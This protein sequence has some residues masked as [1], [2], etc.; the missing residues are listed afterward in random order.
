MGENAD[1]LSNS[2]VSKKIFFKKKRYGSF[3]M[4]I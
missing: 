3:T 2:I 4:Q 1:T